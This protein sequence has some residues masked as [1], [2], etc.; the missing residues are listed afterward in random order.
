MRINEA[1]N[2]QFRLQEIW[3]RRLGGWAIA[4]CLFAPLSA[5]AIILPSL[6]EAANFVVLGLANGDVS[7]NSATSITG[8][9]GYSAGVNVSQAQKVDTFTGAAV[10]SSTATNPG[11]FNSSTF[12]PSLG[13]QCASAANCPTYTSFSVNSNVDTHLNQANID[14]LAAASAYAA[15]GAAADQ[16]LS[17]L[18]SDQSFTASGPDDVY[19]IAINGDINYN[20]NVL[21]LNGRAGHNDAFVIDVTGNMGWSQSQIVLNNVTPDHVIFNF[22]TSGATVDVNKATTVFS[23]VILDPTG[24][25]VYN[26]PATFT[27]ELI[28]KNITLHSDFNIK[29]FQA[30][31]PGTATLL[32]LGLTLITFRRRHRTTYSMAP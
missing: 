13:F 15:L 23:G 14:A 30:P 7:I 4:L 26:N 19:T 21:T 32:L 24:S 12:V 17:G 8:N 22:T 6:G 20:S 5:E 28:A 25:V 1:G 16:S 3:A 18:T 29:Q 2:D 11:N 10:V 9:V 31:A 27:G